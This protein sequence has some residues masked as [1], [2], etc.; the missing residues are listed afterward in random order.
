MFTLECGML[1]LEC[2]GVLVFYVVK[3]HADASIGKSVQF[4]AERTDRESLG[5]PVAR[6]SAVVVLHVVAS[7]GI[8]KRNQFHTRSCRCFRID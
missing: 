4:H 5:H 3:L 7:A 2:E 1:T 6:Y 8:A